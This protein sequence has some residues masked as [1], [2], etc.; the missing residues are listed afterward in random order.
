MGVSEESIEARCARYKAERDRARQDAARLR[1]EL[2]EC[3]EAARWVRGQGGLDAVRE[4]VDFFEGMHDGLYTI[5]ATE[6]H[7]GNEMIREVFDRRKRLMPEGMEWPRF[8]DGELVR[9]GDTAQFDSDDVMEVVGVELR[10]F[11]YVLHGSINDGMRK[12]ADGDEYGVSVKRPAPKVLDAD[13]V[14]I[15]EGDEVW[16][17]GGGMSNIVAE[18]VDSERVHVKFRDLIYYGKHLTH[19]APVIAADGK[20]LREGD[21][22]WGTGRE[23]HEYVVLGQPGLGGGA[24]RFK[25]VCHDVTD[26]VDCDCDPSQLTHERPDSWE[27]W[28]EDAGKSACEY[29]GSFG[30]SC[31]GCQ[32]DPCMCDN[33]RDRDLVRRARALAGR[34][35]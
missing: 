24:G 5:D 10:H 7:T 21:T 35:E 18:I 14:E 32:H 19:R 13:G 2:G 17:T 4:A 8:E 23:E 33:D 34:D 1:A 16:S 25:V 9:I 15:R 27:H 20:P 30:T 22:V 11:G 3:A 28:I 26:D 12:C 29:F 6:R 31:D